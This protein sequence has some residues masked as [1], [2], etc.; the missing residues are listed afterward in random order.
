MMYCAD[1][2]KTAQPCFG[3]DVALAQKKEGFSDEQAAYIT[4]SLLEGGSDT[5]AGTLVGFIQAMMM[6]PEVQKR[7]Q[8]E[9]DRVVGSDRMPQMEDALDLPYIRACVKESIRWM[10]TVIMGVP[11]GLLQDDYYMGYKL[12]AGAAVINNV[13]YVESTKNTWCISTD[14]M[15]RAINMDPKRNPNPRTFDPLRFIDDIRTE[16]ESA[17]SGDVN[18]RQNWIFGAGRR[19]CKGMHIA[20]RSLFL[21]ASRILWGFDIQKALDENGQPISPDVDDLVGGITVQ[22]NDFA[23]RIIPRSKEKADMI[24]KEW[25]FCEDTILDPVTKQ[26]KRVPDGMKFSTYVPEKEDA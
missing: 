24:R 21:A 13:W 9:V 20:E 17:T 10:P 25:Q 1:D 11:H 18:Q 4:G 22:P 14:K 26:W 19:L 5:T 7:A 8:E 2:C 6:W 12:P 23:V 3:I 16:Y 15:S